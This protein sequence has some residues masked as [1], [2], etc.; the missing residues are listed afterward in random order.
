M[1]CYFLL[2]SNHLLDSISEDDQTYEDTYCPIQVPH[3]GFMLK[4]FSADEDGEP[5]D[6]PHQRVESWKEEE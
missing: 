1:T 3:L 5:H 4:H 6:S 2:V